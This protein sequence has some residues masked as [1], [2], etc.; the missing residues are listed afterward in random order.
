MFILSRLFHVIWLCHHLYAHEFRWPFHADLVA[1]VGRD[2]QFA[3]EGGLQS[4][5]H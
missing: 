2:G 3:F 5:Q 1:R 4:V